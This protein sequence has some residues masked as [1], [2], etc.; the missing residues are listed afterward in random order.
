M[1]YW[2]N[3][4]KFFYGLTKFSNAPSKNIIIKRNYYPGLNN[5]QIPSF[6]FY[7]NKNSNM[8][9]IL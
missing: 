4:L 6:E 1:N 7:P 2:Y 5:L 9:M 3:T 8:I